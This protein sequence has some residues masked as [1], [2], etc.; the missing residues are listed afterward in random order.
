MLSKLVRSSLLRRFATANTPATRSA[1]ATQ[2]TEN[3][4]VQQ[5]NSLAVSSAESSELQGVVKSERSHLQFCVN[6]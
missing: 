2:I 1:V 5:D 6:E 4:N 3:L